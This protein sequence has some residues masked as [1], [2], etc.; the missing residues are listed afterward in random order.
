MRP[1]RGRIRPPPSPQHPKP[2]AA[3]AGRA[4]GATGVGGAAGVG[5]A[6]SAGRLRTHDWWQWM[7]AQRVE[8]RPSVEKATMVRGDTAVTA[9]GGK[10]GV[11]ERLVRGGEAGVWT[12]GRRVEAGLE[13]AVDGREAGVVTAGRPVRLASGDCWYS[14]A[15]VPMEV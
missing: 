10:V 9:R 8:V 12:R 4:G 14:S 15:H 5:R 6:A 1:P 13:A 7:R 3:G 11:E 2:T